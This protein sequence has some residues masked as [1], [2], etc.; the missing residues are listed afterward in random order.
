MSEK[1]ER[2][3]DRCPRCGSLDVTEIVYGLPSP[4][5]L[6]RSR[7]ERTVLAGCSIGPDSPAWQCLACDAQWGRA[8]G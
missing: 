4:E 3:G 1:I 5:F 6:E 2:C 8:F 7:H